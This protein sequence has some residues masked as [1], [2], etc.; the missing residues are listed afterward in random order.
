MSINLYRIQRF[1][2]AHEYSKQT[3]GNELNLI[4]SHASVCVF[5]VSRNPHEVLCLYY[6]RVSLTAKAEVDLL[7][8][9]TSSTSVIV[10]ININC[11]VLFWFVFFPCFVHNYV[12]Q[13]RKTYTVLNLFT[14]HDNSFILTQLKHAP[15]YLLKS[16]CSLRLCNE[17]KILHPQK[18]SLSNSGD[19]GLQH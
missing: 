12:F 8:Q 6:T 3:P 19:L 9:R 15:Y 7:T 10:W 11:I 4:L 1:I 2:V 13:I 17:I 14:Y 16:F 18:L 5:G